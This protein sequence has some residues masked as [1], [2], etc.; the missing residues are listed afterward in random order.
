MLSLNN[1]FTLLLVLMSSAISFA[2]S[3]TV[4]VAVLRATLSAKEGL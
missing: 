1:S 4:C 3:S 2:I